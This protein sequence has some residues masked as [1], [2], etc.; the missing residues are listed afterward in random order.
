MMK[1]PPELGCARACGDDLRAGSVFEVSRMTR[2]TGSVDG[3]PFL[4]YTTGVRQRLF[5]SFLLGASAI[6]VAT[7][8]SRGDSKAAAT[9]PPA[10]APGEE[11]AV[12]EEPLALERC[13]RVAE[14]ARV[15]GRLG[16]AADALGGAAQVEP[17]GARKLAWAQALV[18][19][20]PR[21]AKA[22]ALSLASDA[23]PSVRKS[24]LA[25]ASIEVPPPPPPDP[26]LADRVLAALS[27]GQNDVVLQE[28]APRVDS[29]SPDML[30]RL[31]QAYQRDGELELAAEVW[32][33]VRTRHRPDDGWGLTQGGAENITSLRAGPDGV[34]LVTHGEYYNAHVVLADGRTWSG[35]SS[36][37]RS[38]WFGPGR[39]VLAWGLWAM[40]LRDGDSGALVAERKVAKE[41]RRSTPWIL[42]VATAPGAEVSA[43][44]RKDL[45]DTGGTG[46][47]VELIDTSLTIRA[48]FPLAGL[49]VASMAMAPTGRQLALFEYDG[50]VQILDTATM[51]MRHL[52]SL[53]G[54]PTRAVWRADDQLVVLSEDGATR[55]ISARRSARWVV[56]SSGRGGSRPETAMAPTG[57]YV[58]VADMEGLTVF[59]VD[60]GASLGDT[61]PLSRVRARLDRGQK[62]ALTGVLL[63]FAPDGKS[64]VVADAERVIRLAL[65][66]L[67]LLSQW[68]LADTRLRAP[69]KKSRSFGRCLT[70]DPRGL[71]LYTERTD[72]GVAAWELSADRAE[73]WRFSGSG[74]DEELRGA[75]LARKRSGEFVFARSEGGRSFAV[76]R[77]GPHAVVV[78][79]DGADPTYYDYKVDGRRMPVRGV[80]VNDAADTLAVATDKWI[81]LYRGGDETPRKLVNLIEPRKMV[82]DDDA[83][84]LQ[85]YDEEKFLEVWDLATGEM[86]GLYGHADDLGVLDSAT[87]QL[88][89]WRG[90]TLYIASLT[91]ESGK[92]RTFTP[93]GQECRLQAV[94]FTADGSKVEWIAAPGGSGALD[95]RTGESVALRADESRLRAAYR[96][97][98]PDRYP[99][100]GE[101]W[102]PES[103]IL[104]VWRGESQALA[105]AVDIGLTGWAAASPE[106]ILDSSAIAHPWSFALH[107]ADGTLYDLEPFMLTAWAPGMVPALLSRGVPPACSVALESL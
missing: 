73:P 37:S 80:A 77:R 105:L 40:E 81:W 67:Q 22:V 65:P 75:A 46:D 78:I 107:R 25:L 69:Q 96:H 89:F 4:I 36:R 64:L 60:T 23:D 91:P 10:S 44:L 24:A 14:A 50:E 43:V 52:P 106:G 84:L 58:A 100:R 87:D 16:L 53:P 94:S 51:Q 29:L 70:L 103:K 93:C 57:A 97:S 41:E 19:V 74:G 18:P 98:R 48:T 26:G 38:A 72:D 33:K 12:P 30:Y 27:R 83:G 63:D 49:G 3:Q 21:R 31:A 6:V 42:D 2:S 104:R 76:S 35:W 28:L 79:R 66:S 34:T 88:A 54:A 8:C 20:D 99:Q 92:T 68:S 95:L 9:P 55:S 13:L 17:S 85:V 90:S 56:R 101:D 59:D 61:R 62:F 82:I 11:P 1:P 7:A 5:T 32:E 39:R 47:I 86:L 71:R 45:L 102:S 15:D